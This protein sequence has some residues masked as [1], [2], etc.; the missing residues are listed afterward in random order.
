MIVRK[1]TA[2]DHFLFWGFTLLCLTGAILVFFRH[3]SQSISLQCPFHFL[4]GLYCPGC[5]STRSLHYLLQGDVATSFRYQPLMFPTLLILAVL[6]AQQALLALFGKTFTLPG[7]RLL[8]QIVLIVV[9]VYF[10]LRNLPL[11]CFDSLR[12]IP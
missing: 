12:P 11:A 3:P 2:S 5:G 4:T 8:G 10:V 1:Y 9:V 7:A 6:Y